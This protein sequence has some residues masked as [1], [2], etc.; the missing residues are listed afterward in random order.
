MVALEIEMSF[1][2]LISLMIPSAFTVFYADFLSFHVPFNFNILQYLSTSKMYS[3][4]LCAHHVAWITEGKC[5]WPGTVDGA[6]VY[7]YF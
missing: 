4:A 6:G 1:P 2:L 5:A 7:I 3:L